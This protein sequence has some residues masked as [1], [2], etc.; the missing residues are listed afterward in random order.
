MPRQKE[1]RDLIDH[2][3]HVECIPGFG[4][5]RR[6]DFRRK[7]IGNCAVLDLIKAR[8]RESGALLAGEMS[9]HFFFAERWFGFDDGLYAGARLL[10]I[11]SGSG[12]PS[13]D[14]F[15][16]LP[17]SLSTPELK[18]TVPEGAQH[19]I[20]ERLVAQGQAQFPDAEVI[21]ID[22]LRVEFPEGW[23]LVRA[24]NTT[25]NLILRFEADSTEGLQAI[26]QRFGALLQAVEPGL[27]LPF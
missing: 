1:D 23:G 9:G 4:I 2:L 5:N 16:G 13:S 22:G 8:L 18:I 14:V 24:S 3:F 10:E 26:Q 27:Q 7:I 15:A 17:D 20:V 19:G 21:T 12:Q 6:H 25:P 11:L